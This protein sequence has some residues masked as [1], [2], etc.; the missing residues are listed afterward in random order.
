MRCI[1][2]W[3]RRALWAAV[4][5]VLADAASASTSAS[6]SAKVQPEH[7]VGLRAFS[8]DDGLPQSGVNAVVQARDGY[9]WI[10][11]FG[12]LARFDG[13]TFKVFRSNASPGP[14]QSQDRAQAG[15]A[16]DRIVALHEDDRRWLWI[17]TQDAG[18][19]V[20]REGA[21][22]HL[23]VCGGTCQINDILQTPDR[24]V[25]IATTVGLLS[26]DPVHQRETWVDYGSVGHTRL[27]RDGK[28]A[29][30]AGGDDGLFVM[31][32]GQLRRI[33]MP[34]GNDR[35]NVLKPD[36]DDL[37]VGTA[38]ALYRYDPDPNPDSVDP[39]HGQW[40]ALGVAS[41]IAAVKDADGRW[42]VA[43]VSGR[44]LQEDGAGGWRDIPELFGKGVTSLARDDEGN[45]WIGSG[46]KGLL[47]VR[48]PLF[49]LI[50]APKA[51][52]NMAG[53]A[54]IADGEGGLWFGSACAGLRHWRRDGGM[55]SQSIL[56]TSDEECVTTLSLDPAGALWVGLAQGRLVRVVGGKPQRIGAWEAGVPINVWQYGDGRLLIASGRST[57]VVA[58]DAEG[59]I[60]EQHRIDALQGMS[61]NNV[62][63]AAR[64]G[65]W[66]VGDRGVWRLL[67]ERVVERWTPEQG[68]SSRFARTV[69]EDP[70]TATL[71]VGTYGGGLN[72]IHRGQ[73]RRYDSQN[74][75][76]DDTVSCILPDGQGRLW[77]G[78][79]RGVTLLPTPRADTA[80]IESVG[81]TASD[82][83]IPAEV[84]GG[85]SSS[86]HRDAQ[87]RLW[88]SLVEGFAVID[89]AAVTDVQPVPLRP[90]IE[91]VAIAGRSQKIAGSSLALQPFARSLEIHY[92]AINLS[93]PWET[94][95]R[96]RLLGFDHDWVEAG[97]NRSI[98]YTSI[99]WGEHLFE[100]QAR[101]QGGRWSP[102]SA[103]LRIVNPQPWYL[104]PWILILATSLGLL[105]LVGGTQFGASQEGAWVRRNP[106]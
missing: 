23:P 102:A 92:S 4:V 45:V 48:K 68:L 57:F 58:I 30:Y 81:Y 7:R 76:F 96:F 12:G 21:F 25:W 61:I 11:T 22:H 105:A 59:R 26:L 31:A 9:L 43:T 70:A 24:T 29:L 28:G 41:P 50:R 17:G 84:N 95:Y 83:L 19:S 3:L 34:D 87:G 103:S 13:L 56:Q 100:V 73:V 54:V 44:L 27:A 49:G 55:V 39:E 97:Q 80:Q 18:L 14:P 82:G 104:R 79:N 35:V 52:V 47:R 40:R 36:G 67:D 37:L 64:G 38:H 77:L 5:F 62:V 99:P 74:G 66:F 75:L 8:G 10:G 42:W 16:S 98:L 20:Y 94:R 78:G 101:S 89:P 72:R 93:R 2:I 63:A 51:G 33:A 15:P 6:T 86:C 65:H 69:Y 60:G 46:S 91:E 85:H 32:D 88:F 106:D 1:E 90:H 71:W 53:R